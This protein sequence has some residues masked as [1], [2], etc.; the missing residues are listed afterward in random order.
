MTMKKK[1][2]H[3]QLSLSLSF[4]NNLLIGSTDDVNLATNQLTFH[5]LNRVHI[6]SSADADDDFLRVFFLCQLTLIGIA[7]REINN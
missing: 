2:K 5:H 4:D 6:S 1:C 3:C 7:K